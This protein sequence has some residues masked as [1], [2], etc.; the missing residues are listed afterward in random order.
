[1]S[2]GERAGEVVKETHSADDRVDTP[3]QL[4]SLVAGPLSAASAV[5]EG[6]CE[7]PVRDFLTES[8]LADDRWL[9]T[10]RGRV[11]RDRD[12][13]RAEASQAILR[14]MSRSPGRMA[15]LVSSNVASPRTADLSTSQAL[16]MEA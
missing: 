11:R 8:D 7:P 5:Y 4:V 16:T 15:V 3:E 9:Q 2:C 12:G 14:M 13:I 1:M 6:C 10:R